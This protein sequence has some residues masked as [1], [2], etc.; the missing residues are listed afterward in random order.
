MLASA[1]RV[2]R[3]F[4]ISRRPAVRAMASAASDWLKQDKRRMLHVVYRVGDMQKHIDWY[5]K[6]LGM[7][8]LRYRD[9]PEGKY[10]NA[11]L[12]YNSEEKGFAL[13]LTYNYGVDSYDIGEGFGHFGVAAPDVYKLAETIRGG[14]GKITREPGPVKGGATVIAFAEDP[15][16]Y[17]WEL[18]QRAKT[19]EPLC[20]VMLRVGDLEKS[21]AWY[22]DVLGMQVLRTRD[23][24]EYK[25]TLGFVGYGPEEDNCVIELTYNYGRT[26]YSKGNAYAQVALSTDDVY[27][28]AE[29]IRAAG[30]TIT[31]EP[32]PVPGIGT[33]ILACTDPDGYKYVFVDSEDFLKELEAAAK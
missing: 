13:E 21:Q 33:K 28:T 7:K 26:E 12:G 9:I 29:Q 1:S 19:E 27:K 25:Y 4:T 16:G 24:P 32:G 10:S 15:T 30:G 23:N 8:L 22:R 2:A 31:R 3:P 6:L 18:I 14:G 20:Q 5:T 17:K 11:F